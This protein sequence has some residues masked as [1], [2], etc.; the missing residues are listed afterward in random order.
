MYRITQQSHGDALITAWN[1][2]IPVRYIGETEEYRLVSRLWVAYNMDRMYA[3]GIPMKVRAHAGLNHQKLLLFYGQ[4]T[5]V[6]GSSNFTSPS[7]NSQQENN[8]FTKKDRDLPVA[9]GS[10]RSAVEQF[11][12]DRR[13]RNRA[14]RTAA[15]RQARIQQHRK[16]SG[17]RAADRAKAGVV[18]R[19]VGA[20]VRHLLRYRSRGDDAVRRP[21]S[22]SVPAKR[23]RRTRALR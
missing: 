7:D 10:V 6:F 11:R 14:L 18:R 16:R 4:A 12:T 5:A 15:A 1:R 19:A 22:R 9:A 2:G 21:P 13:R 17:R 20:H 8:Y 3:A 23:R